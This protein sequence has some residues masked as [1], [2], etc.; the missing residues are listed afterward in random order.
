MGT[1]W[2]MFNTCYDRGVAHIAMNITEYIYTDSIGCM[3]VCMPS[4]Q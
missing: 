1:W 2:T 4:V 3:N